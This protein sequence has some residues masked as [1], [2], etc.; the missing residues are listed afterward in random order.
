MTCSAG[1]AGAVYATG[2]DI[3]HVPP[4]KCHVSRQHRGRGRFLAAGISYGMVSNVPINEPVR[5]GVSAATLTLQL[6]KTV[7]S[8][9]TLERLYAQTP[10]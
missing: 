1:R 10:V 7:S 4:T 6:A 5:L 3:G 2:S 9:L 8:V